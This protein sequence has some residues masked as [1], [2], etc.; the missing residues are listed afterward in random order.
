MTEDSNGGVSAG[1]VARLPEITPNS[2]PPPPEAG[3]SL[4]S[5]VHQENLSSGLHRKWAIY[6]RHQGRRY[7][8]WFTKLEGLPFTEKVIADRMPYSGFARKRVTTG[9]CC[10]SR[11]LCVKY[12]L[13]NSIRG[14]FHYRKTKAWFCFAAEFN[15]LR[16]RIRRHFH[17]PQG[18]PDL[19]RASLI[20]IFRAVTRFEQEHVMTSNNEPVKPPS[21]RGGGGV[22][23]QHC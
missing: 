9:S 4:G 18:S 2:P 5:S 14:V 7:S 22:N 21:I 8:L 6:K 12:S 16:H 13:K 19:I 1:R 23:H 17:V 11:Q 3:A 10:G 20:Y 15:G